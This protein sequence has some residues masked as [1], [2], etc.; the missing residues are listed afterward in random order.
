MQ[1]FQANLQLDI[2]EQDTEKITDL[3][4]L[5]T[6][7][8]IEQQTIKRA[9]TFGEIFNHGLAIIN[10][11]ALMHV[12]HNTTNN[13]IFFV[14]FYMPMILLFAKM[15][16][17]HTK[18]KQIAKNELNRTSAQN[19]ALITVLKSSNKQTIH[20]I[21]EM[22]TQEIGDTPINTITEHQAN[23]IIHHILMRY[24]R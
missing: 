21:A 20:Q 7:L 24:Q 9:E 12:L 10:S 16:F 11:L 14:V 13:K 23:N 3:V 17:T 1:K 4:V 18:Q 6:A 19:D 8:V 2:S 22:Y 15:G 5:S